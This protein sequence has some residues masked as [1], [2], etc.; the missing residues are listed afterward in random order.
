MIETWYKGNGLKQ[1][2]LLSSLINRPLNAMTSYKE[3]NL[4]SLHSFLFQCH[5]HKFIENTPKK[6]H[7]LKR[8]KN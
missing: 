8:H 2:K 3:I 7:K 6:A 4:S 5:T 1:R